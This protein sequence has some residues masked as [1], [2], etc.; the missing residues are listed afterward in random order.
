MS[1]DKTDP[2]FDAIYDFNEQVIGTPVNQ[3]MGPLTQ[4]QFDWTLKA[5]HE[6][7]HEFVAAAHSQDMVKMVDSCLDLIYFAVGTM[8]KLGVN[9]EQAYA[10]MMAIHEANMCKKKGVVT[11]RG[12][13]EDAFKPSDFVPPDQTIGII[14]F[15]DDT[16]IDD[17]HH[18]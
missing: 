14:L 4:A 5:W 1:D 15:G 12:G 11:S 2:I 10:C 8:K 6:E 17:A 18:S 16:E 7:I 13:D 9:R 3:P